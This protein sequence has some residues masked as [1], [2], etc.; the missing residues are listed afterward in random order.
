MIQVAFIFYLSP[1]YMIAS[2]CIDYLE[3]GMQPI[4]GADMWIAPFAQEAFD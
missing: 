3:A 2:D 4:E 1:Q